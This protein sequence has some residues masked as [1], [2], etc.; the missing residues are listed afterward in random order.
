MA[1]MLCSLSFLACPIFTGG[2]RMLSGILLEV[3]P[4]PEALQIEE[5]STTV[6]SLH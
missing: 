1:A 4:N 2:L 6:C 5:G 3:G